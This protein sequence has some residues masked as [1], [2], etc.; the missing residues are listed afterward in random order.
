MPTKTFVFDGLGSSRTKGSPVIG[1]STWSATKGHLERAA[2]K[3]ELKLGKIQTEIYVQSTFSLAHTPTERL[4]EGAIHFPNTKHSSKKPSVDLNSTR[5]PKVSH[6]D[7]IPTQTPA[8]G[9]GLGNSP[10]RQAVSPSDSKLKRAMG[11]GKRDSKPDMAAKKELSAYE[12]IVQQGGGTPHHRADHLI[13][14]RQNSIISSP[15]QSMRR[16]AIA[17]PNPKLTDRSERLFSEEIQAQVGYT[18]QFPRSLLKHGAALHNDSRERLSQKDSSFACPSPLLS[19]KAISTVSC[20]AKSTAAGTMNLSKRQTA[21]AGA[22]TT[23][24]PANS[25]GATQMKQP[26]VSL[27][28]GAKPGPLRLGTTATK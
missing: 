26:R 18:S 3:P 16:D 13:T 25:K 7:M 5:K 15:T 19:G 24:G 8:G 17:G 28:T 12:W 22:K 4:Q 23:P 27:H 9:V 11:E 14:T 6:S 20:Q 2:K 21:V 1:K 10:K